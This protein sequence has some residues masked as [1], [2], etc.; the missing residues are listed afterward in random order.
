MPS[1]SPLQVGQECF[2]SAMGRVLVVEVLGMKGD[3]IWVSYPAVDAIKD[4]TGVELSFRNQ[5]GFIGFH[6]RVSSGAK[7]GQTGIMLERSESADHGKAR[8]DWRVPCKLPIAVKRYGDPKTV[9][10]R[11]IDLTISGAMIAT[12]FSAEAGSMLELQFDLPKAPVPVMVL[13]QIVYADPT[14]EGDINRYGL[15][16]IELTRPN[17][18]ALMWFLYEQ[19]QSNYPKELRALYPRPSRKKKVEG[20]EARS[21]DA[22]KP[23]AQA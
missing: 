20:D 18:E 1:Q 3:T 14:P 11:I 8:R 2:L 21:E 15:R 4:G 22:P 19:I 12:N 17:R 9:T 5:H 23:P 13:A 16:F 6:T 10:G 7:P